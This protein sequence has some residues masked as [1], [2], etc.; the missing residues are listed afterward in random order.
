MLETATSVERLTLEN[1]RAREWGAKLTPEF[2]LGRNDRIYNHPYARNRI[3][4]LLWKERGEILSSMDVLDVDLIVNRQE[5]KRAPGILIA[6]V[7]TEPHLRGHGYASKMLTAFFDERPDVPGVLYS[8][9]GA[10]FYRRFGFREK[11]VTSVTVPARDSEARPSHLSWEEGLKA[12]D[13]ER[14]AKVREAAAPALAVQP[15]TQFLDWQIERYR[16]FA[17]MAEEKPPKWFFWEWRNIKVFA[18]PHYLF[19]QLEVFWMTELNL[20]VLSAIAREMN[21]SQILFWGKGEGKEEVP[22]ARLG[23]GNAPAA[24]LDPQLCGWW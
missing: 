18:V 23:A 5:L 7:V 13:E 20:D 4:T 8:D 3:T 15:E 10:A 9:I 14:W 16:F 24:F 2:Y 11:I 6:N 19:D 17:D 22:M 12:M 21:V 1:A